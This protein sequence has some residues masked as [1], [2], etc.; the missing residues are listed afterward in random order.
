MGPGPDVR[1][2]RDVNAWRHAA[3]IMTAGAVL[4][5]PVCVAMGLFAGRLELDL[6]LAIF[7]CLLG[8][9]VGDAARYAAGVRFGRALLDRRLIASRV[10]VP[11]DELSD[12]L[13]RRGWRAVLLCRFMPGHRSAILI[14]AGTVGYAPWKMA[15]RSIGATIVRTPLLVAGVA[16]FG[17]TI[18]VP[19]R[20]A[21]GDLTALFISVAAIL[22]LLHVM[23]MM[24]TRAG[25]AL[26]LLTGRPRDRM[27]PMSD[28][29]AA[30]DNPEMRTPDEIS[31]ADR[32]RERLRDPDRAP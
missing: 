26:S 22:L 21:S 19:W 5:G 23:A 18:H 9:L 12:L 32:T 24:I 31:N 8:T 25:D 3:L 16:L 27:V 13:D 6:F 28:P 10:P 4:D 11:L 29:V 30:D 1:V 14:A 17:E 7:G 20:S 15:I 2:K